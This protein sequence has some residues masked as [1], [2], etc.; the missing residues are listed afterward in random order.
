MPESRN[1]HGIDVFDTNLRGE[2]T[3]ATKIASVSNL[4]YPNN[5][6]DF[7]LANQS[8]EHWHEYY[9]VGRRPFRDQ[10]GVKARW[11]SRHKFPDSLARE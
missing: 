3:I 1:W 4:P 10:K 5:S 8:I 6:F 7:V 11:K 2:K 9:V